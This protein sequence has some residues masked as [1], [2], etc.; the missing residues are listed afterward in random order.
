M[1]YWATKGNWSSSA[2]H[3]QQ[4]HRQSWQCACIMAARQEDSARAWSREL[5]EELKSGLAAPL[6]SE[7]P[8]PK[9]KRKTKPMTT[10]RRRIWQHRLSCDPHPNPTQPTAQRYSPIESSPAT[11]RS[12]L[13][14]MVPKKYSLPLPSPTRTNG[15]AGSRF[16]PTS[17]GGAMHRIAPATCTLPVNGGVARQPHRD[18]SRRIAPRVG[19]AR[20]PVD[21]I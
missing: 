8:K 4:E 12:P 19:H 10:R 21:A 7:A 17:R 3:S 13:Q 15:S 16:A 14:R 9:L 20:K 11:H 5:H 2:P 18:R 1:T 6:T